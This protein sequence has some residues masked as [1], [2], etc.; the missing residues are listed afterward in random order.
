MAHDGADLG[1][2]LDGVPYLLVQY[3]AVRDDDGQIE[4]RVA[5]LLQPD[6]LVGQ[7][8]DGVRLAAARRVLNQILGA[9][10]R[11]GCVSQEPA[12]HV[13]LVE[14]GPYLLSPLASR[15]IVPRLHD[16]SVV[17]NDVGEPVAGEDL[18]PQVVGLEAVGGWADCLCHRSTPCRRAGTTTPCL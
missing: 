18:L 17:L 8:R 16:L 5:V 2:L 1:E 14:A 12:H 13:Q 10:S 9:D 7:P 3:P 15:L 11:D 4:E 6:E